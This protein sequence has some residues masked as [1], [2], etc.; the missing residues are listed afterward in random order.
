[1]LAMGRARFRI[2]W[3]S[4]NV[5]D[6]VRSSPLDC[7]G[8]GSINHFNLVYNSTRRAERLLM[9]GG[10]FRLAVTAV[11]SVGFC[12]SARLLRMMRFD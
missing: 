4:Y 11:S 5:G 3:F 10:W 8:R 7:V 9:G 2:L 6:N 12:V 1:M